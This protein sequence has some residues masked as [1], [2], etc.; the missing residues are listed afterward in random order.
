MPE[1][2]VRWDTARASPATRIIPQSDKFARRYYPRAR[3]TNQYEHAAFIA[4]SH[5]ACF[6]YLCHRQQ[7]IIIGVGG[8]FNSRQWTDNLCQ[9][10]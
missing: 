8:A 10:S 5:I 2:S 1:P 4:C 3:M 7:K 6:S 9:R